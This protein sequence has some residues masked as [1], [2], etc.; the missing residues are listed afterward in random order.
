MG[1]TRGSPCLR[2]YK[3]ISATDWSHAEAQPNRWTEPLGPPSAL[4]LTNGGSLSFRQLVAE[5]P[6]MICRPNATA[7]GKTCG[8]GAGYVRLSQRH[9]LRHSVAQGQLACQC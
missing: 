1:K 9:R 3:S 8:D 6:Q 7:K 2:G 5:L 4:S